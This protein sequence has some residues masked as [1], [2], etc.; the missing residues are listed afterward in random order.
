MVTAV[1]AV[2]TAA[3]VVVVMLFI[4][5]LF[6]RSIR[7]KSVDRGDALEKETLLNVVPSP[8]QPTKARADK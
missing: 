7:H 8:I 4:V 2:V 3:I 1:V 6:I 5:E